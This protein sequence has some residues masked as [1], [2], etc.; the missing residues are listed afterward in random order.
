[1]GIVMITGG[2]RSGKSVQAEKMCREKGRQVAYI[3]AAVVTDDDMA[4]RIAHHRA[5]RPRGWVTIEQPRGY[6][7]LRD[8]AR[9]SGCDVLLFDCV[10]TMI[11]NHMMASGLDFDTCGPGDMQWLEDSIRVDADDLL[12]LAK[13]R[14]MVVVTNEVGQGVVPAYRM[15]R[16]FADISGRINA[17]I[18]R[19]ADDVYCMISGL[20]LKLK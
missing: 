3:A 15:G 11:T 10:T 2:A 14:D 19:Q 13:G 12:A 8:D 1:M 7:A 18:A 6:A 17:H 16:L 5:R 4:D 20:S 9:L